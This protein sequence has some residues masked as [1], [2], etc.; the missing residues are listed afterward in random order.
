MPLAAGLGLITRLRAGRAST[1]IR[2]K[3]MSLLGSKIKT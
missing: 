1:L 3:A 2:V